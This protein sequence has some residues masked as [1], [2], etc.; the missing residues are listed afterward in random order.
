MCH[1]FQNRIMRSKLEPRIIMEAVILQNIETC[2]DYTSY[3]FSISEIILLYVIN[4]VQFHIKP[5]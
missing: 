1:A 2:R 5:E 3:M 4:F